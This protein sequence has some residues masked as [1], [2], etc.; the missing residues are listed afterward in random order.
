MCSSKREENLYEL[1][2]ARLELEQLAHE[3]A[4]LRGDCANLLTHICNFERDALPHLSGT[5]LDSR[6]KEVCA[7]S[8]KICFDRGI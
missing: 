2:A 5:G 1:N 3:Y 8:A 6:L 7:R 4:N